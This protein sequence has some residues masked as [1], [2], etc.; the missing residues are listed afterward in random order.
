LKRRIKEMQIVIAAKTDEL[1]A[2]KRNMKS[3]KTQELEAEVRVYFEECS[4]L[5]T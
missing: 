5:R 1:E 2:I 4:R 3:T